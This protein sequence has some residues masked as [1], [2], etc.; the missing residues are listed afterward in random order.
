LHRDPS[1]H[2]HGSQAHACRVSRS[3]TL[4]RRCHIGQLGVASAGVSLSPFLP[5]RDCESGRSGP[6]VAPL[7]SQVSRWPVMITLA[8]QRGALPAGGDL[9]SA[10][11]KG[12]GDNQ[13]SSRLHPQ[14][15]RPRSGR[16]GGRNA[17][18]EGAARWRGA[19]GRRS[20]LRLRLGWPGMAMAVF[21]PSLACQRPRF[22]PPARIRVIVR[23]RGS[24]ERT[25]VSR[26]KQMMSCQP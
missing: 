24:G 6:S 18:A 23:L 8:C 22:W 10:R 17:P 13:A 5:M 19:G 11:C 12:A 14:G 4:S 26:R 2:R 9:A 1:C 21:F 20:S 16:C 3:L 15:M 25:A 7:P